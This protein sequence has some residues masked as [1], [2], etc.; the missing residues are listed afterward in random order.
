MTGIDVKMIRLVVFASLFG[1]AVLCIV[2]V[3]AFL[4][5]RHLTSKIRKWKLPSLPATTRIKIS[6]SPL[7]TDAHIKL[8]HQQPRLGGSGMTMAEISPLVRHKPL[9]NFKPVDADPQPMGRCNTLT[10]QHQ[11]ASSMKTLIRPLSQSAQYL[12]RPS[13]QMFQQTS[14]TNLIGSHYTSDS[15]EGH[16]RNIDDCQQTPQVELTLVYVSASAQLLVHVHRLSNVTL[17]RYGKESSNV[18]VKVALDG[19]IRRVF[20]S[21]LIAPVSSS[22]GQP[23]KSQQ[24]QQ[25]CAQVFK[26]ADVTTDDLLNGHLTITIYLVRGRWKSDK[27]IGFFTLRLG[28]MA[29]ADGIP[30]S[31]TGFLSHD[32]TDGVGKNKKDA[33]TEPC[34]RITGVPE[35]GQLLISL[36]REQQSTAGTSS[37]RLKI[38]I[39]RAHG[40]PSTKTVFEPEYI[41]MVNASYP[42]GGSEIKE[43]KPARGKAPEW[44]Q[45]IEFDVTDRPIVS[46]WLHLVLIRKTKKGHSPNATV[47]HLTLGANST[48]DGERHWQALVNTH[49]VEI[50]QWHRLTSR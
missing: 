36:R 34:R 35:L 28:E 27:K 13:S 12:A 16:E 40:L 29:L 43:T 19:R 8:L 24:P 14:L 18:T 11:V 22:I 39:H 26:F 2:A 50:P 25:R 49:D 41:V 33:Q 6:G 37:F 5:H 48:P 1:V 17:V 45:T 15:N 38:L 31:R 42:D 30:Q 44:N 4:L 7:D 46:C 10:T 21:V 32:K 3:C 47:G 9:C 23:T 20:R